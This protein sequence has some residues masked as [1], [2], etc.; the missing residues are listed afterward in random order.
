M[1]IQARTK[2][3]V[4][5]Y[6]KWREKLITE[7]CTASKHTGTLCHQQPP[8]RYTLLS[9]RQPAQ[10]KVKLDVTNTRTSWL[11]IAPDLHLWFK[12]RRDTGWA[13]LKS[14]HLCVIYS[15]R[16]IHLVSVRFLNLFSSSN[17][18][19][20]QQRN[21]PQ[22]PP[23]CSFTLRQPVLSFCSRIQQNTLPY[24]TPSLLTTPPKADNVIIQYSSSRKFSTWS[25]LFQPFSLF[26][27]DPA[28]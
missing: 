18:A 17:L 24:C 13:L 5:W 27:Q 21:T 22:T 14:S 20:F 3:G 26:H 9:P 16:W 19:I 23:S 7:I 15:H 28:V 25:F 12:T 11:T 6:W 8:L 10:T 4:V 2:W 1:S